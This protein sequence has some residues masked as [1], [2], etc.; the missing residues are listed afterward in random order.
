[1]EHYIIQMVI[2]HIKDNGK[3]IIFMEKE[4]YLMISHSLLMENMTI[5]IVKILIR[6]GLNMM[7][8]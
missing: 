2:L 3:W 6:Y 1:M 4:K 7:G 8:S 5:K